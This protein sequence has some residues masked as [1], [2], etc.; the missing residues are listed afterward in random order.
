MEQGINLEIVSRSDFAGVDEL[1][2]RGAEVS[3]ELVAEIDLN[4]KNKI[5]SGQCP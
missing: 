1:H 3:E 4:G 2:V 5:Y